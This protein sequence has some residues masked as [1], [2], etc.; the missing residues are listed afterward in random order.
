MAA[1]AAG[2]AALWAGGGCSSTPP[3]PSAEAPA[4]FSV[5]V[6]VRVPDA[7]ADAWTA[8]DRSQPRAVR[9]ARYLLEADDLLR[10]VIGPG[11]LPKT[12]PPPTRRLTKSQVD[13]LWHR[14]RDSGLLTEGEQASR[15]ALGQEFADRPAPVSEPMALMVIRAD[16]HRIYRREAMAP[17]SAAYQLTDALAELAWIDP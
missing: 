16:G 2:V 11:G 7:Q 12:F 6:V 17:G 15:E 4:D 14:V 3:A 5:A 9:P 10:V 8:G 13:A 1:I